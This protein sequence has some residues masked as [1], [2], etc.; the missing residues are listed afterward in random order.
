MPSLIVNLSK[1]DVA[2]CTLYSIR[3]TRRGLKDDIVVTR[4]EEVELLH[5][6]T[7]AAPVGGETGILSRI[8]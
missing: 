8:N 1:L 6:A 3:C 4:G 5:V 7:R 2:S